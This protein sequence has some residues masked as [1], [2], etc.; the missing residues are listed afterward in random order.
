MQCFDAGAEAFGW[1][2]RNPEPRSMRD[3][4]WL[5]GWG[6]ASTIYPTHIGAGDGARDA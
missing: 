5:V 4:D 2:A 3:G 1:K 6:C